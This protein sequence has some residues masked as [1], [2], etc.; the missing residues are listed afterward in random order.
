MRVNYPVLAVLLT[1]LF[2]WYACGKNTQSNGQEVTGTEM[3]IVTNQGDIYLFGKKVELE[4]LQA[5]LLD[6]LSKLQLVPDT[7]SVQ[8]G[9]EILMGMRAEVRTEIDAALQAAKDARQKPV[10]EALRAAVEDSLTAP[11]SIQVFQFKVIDTIAFVVGTFLQSDGSAFDFSKTPFKQAA[12][13]GVF[14]DSVFGLLKNQNGKWTVLTSSV[15]ATDVPIVC[16][17]KE[18]GVPKTLFPEDMVAEDCE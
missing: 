12:E 7:L 2:L 10:L 5:R 3:V 4:N 8:F 15:G 11:V 17:W 16:W 6:S 1:V 9:D 13:A 18:F 14:S